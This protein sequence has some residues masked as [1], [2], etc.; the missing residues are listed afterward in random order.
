MIKKLQKRFIAIAMCSVIL[1]LTIIVGSINIINYYNVNRTA[2]E[3]LSLLSENNGFFPENTISGNN[4]QANTPQGNP[5]QEGNSPG[6]QPGRSEANPFDGRMGLSAETPFD[7]RYFTVTL[8]ADGTVLSSNTQSIAAISEEVARSYA[9]SLF[10]AGKKQGFLGNYKYRRIALSNSA[11]PDSFMYIFLDCT[12]ELNTFH[13][14]LFA[15]IGISLAGICVMLLLIFLFSRPV[16]R[17][18]AESYEKQR[19]FITDASHEIKTPLT[20]IEA[21]T[22]VIEMDHGESEWTESIRNQVKRLTGL[23][24]KLVFL[25]RMEEEDN[26]L[27]MVDFSLSDAVSETAQ[28]FEAVAAAQQKT[29]TFEIEPRITYHGDEASLRQ[30]VSLLLDN[31]MKYSTENGAIRLTLSRSGK[32]ITLTLWNSA[33]GLTPGKQDILFERFYRPD[34]SRSRQTGGSG[35]GLSVAQAIVLAHKGKISAR[36]DDGVSILFTIT[37]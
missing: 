18:I 27:T 37:L 15:S 36:S 20:I 33:Q 23:T 17:P 34:S 16:M 32:N 25:S 35:I 9:S 28:S 21:N 6:N 3:K 22:E 2:D 7:T 4:P 12:R 5:P 24:E 31:A 13:T 11:A 8:A 26:P 14:F 10:S 30:C 1:V 29:L 19:R